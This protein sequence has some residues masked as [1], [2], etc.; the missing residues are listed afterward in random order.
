MYQRVMVPLDGSELA[1][2]VIPHVEAIAKGCQVKE[3]L[4]V[5]AVQKIDQPR[6]AY[7]FVIPEGDRK[8]FEKEAQTS[9]EN[10]MKQLVERPVFKGVNKRW[11]VI[12]GPIADSLVDYAKNHEVDLI[13][14]A[15]HGRSGISRW[16]LGSIAE[17]LLRSSSAPVLIVR[18]AGCE[19]HSV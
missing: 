1:E 10:Y 15:S 18:A 13:I 11:E 16:V 19:Q 7:S 9:A 12:V 17:R 8:R 4:F 14:I 3:V 2:C 6:D 5:R